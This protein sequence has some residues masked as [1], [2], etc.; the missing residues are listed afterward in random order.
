MKTI[1]TKIIIFPILA[2][3][4]F[5]PAVNCAFAG[6]AFSSLQDAAISPS[7]A[8]DGSKSY[9]GSSLPSMKSTSRSYAVKDVAPPEEPKPSIWEKT[10]E[11][12]KSQKPLIILAGVGAGVGFLIAGSSGA[13]IGAG[14]LVLYMLLVSL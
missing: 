4:L 1:K 9:S 2:A 14:A 3:L 13:L 8:F 6:D 12:I 5:S 7:A 10:K 11:V